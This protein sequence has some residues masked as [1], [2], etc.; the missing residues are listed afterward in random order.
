MRW[1]PCPCCLLVIGIYINWTT[2][3]LCINRLCTSIACV[4]CAWQ[5]QARRGGA[6]RCQ[7]LVRIHPQELLLYGR[8]IHRL[9]I[10]S[11]TCKANVVLLEPQGL[12]MMRAISGR[13]RSS[14]I[15]PYDIPMYGAPCNI[16][17]P[18]SGDVKEYLMWKRC[19]TPK[20]GPLHS[21]T[22][23]RN[24]AVPCRYLVQHR[25]STLEESIISRRLATKGIAL[26]IWFAL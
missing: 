5:V 13:L 9:R 4:T 3:A 1:L 6:S 21:T 15:V 8:D 25:C 23:C 18:C 10:L 12:H 20:D 17:E 7:P 11:A 2:F 22:D 26:I 14:W 24:I 19:A 16:C